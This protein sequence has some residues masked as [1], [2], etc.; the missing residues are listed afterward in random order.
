MGGIM[1]KVTEC[2]KVMIFLCVLISFP[3]S[4][5]FSY[6][7]DDGA[8]ADSFLSWR[9]LL[10]DVPGSDGV[11]L[12]GER[13][14]FVSADDAESALTS[15]EG[16]LVK[17]V[18]NEKGEVVL[19]RQDRLKLFESWKRSHDGLWFV[20]NS[21][22]FQVSVRDNEG[23]V[24]FSLIRPESELEKRERIADENRNIPLD[25]SVYT[26]K[27]FNSAKFISEYADWRKRFA[28]DIDDLTRLVREGALD[29]DGA[30]ELPP[31]STLTR[32]VWPALVFARNKEGKL[33]LYALSSEM[34]QIIQNIY[35]RQ[36][37]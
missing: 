14:R 6:A 1:L 2:G 3:M 7:A 36:L 28:A 10:Q 9:I 31:Y 30:P 5:T 22:V 15:P 19:S 34:N 35:R 11:P 17:G 8:V 24:T 26:Q 32:N 4:F 37:Y 20:K 13:W 27:D 23:K 33:L 16:I 18:T 21:K 29:A 25:A 12:I